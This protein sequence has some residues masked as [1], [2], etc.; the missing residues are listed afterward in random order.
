[1]LSVRVQNVGNGDSIIIE[2]K[3]DDKSSYALID[4]N[5]PPGK[6]HTVKEKLLSLGVSDLSFV[7][8]THPHKD[9]YDGLLEIFRSFSVKKFI[10]FPIDAFVLEKSRIKNMAKLYKRISDETDSPEIKSSIEE[11]LLLLQTAKTL[12]KDNWEEPAGIE[13]RVLAEGFTDDIDLFVVQ[14]LRSQKGD[15]FSALDNEKIEIIES[16]DINKLSLAF[17]IRYKGHEILLGGDSTVVNWRELQTKRYQRNLDASVVKLP[18]HGSKKDCAADVLDFVYAGDQAERIAIISA[19]GKKHPD[20]ETLVWLK[21]R[22]IKPYCTGLATL[23][24]DKVADLHNYS[25]FEPSLAKFIAA[26]AEPS[27][28]MVRPCQGEVILS[29]DSVGK[30]AVDSEYRAFCPYRADI[31]GLFN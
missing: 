18:H 16:K 10:T 5:V 2:Y 27:E 30:L 23:C 19:N 22:N 14:P 8:L 29:I 21:E 12:G 6:E 13:S 1:M 11:F 24:H 7:A 28:K 9:H 25:E 15:F 4:C 26:N 3:Y 20:A 31:P 17:L